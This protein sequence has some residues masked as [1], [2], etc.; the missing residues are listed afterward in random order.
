MSD[1]RDERQQ[2]TREGDEADR[3][4]SRCMREGGCHFPGDCQSRGHCRLSDTE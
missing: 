1:R 3:V 2:S 4:P